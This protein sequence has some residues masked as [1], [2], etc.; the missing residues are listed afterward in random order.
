M[1]GTLQA[2]DGWKDCLRSCATL[3]PKMQVKD[4]CGI[5]LISLFSDG[6]GALW[7]TILFI[8]TAEATARSFM[9]S[10]A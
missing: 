5:T 7:N 8:S 3:H 9:S 1:L 4:Y 6:L 2:Q 10:A